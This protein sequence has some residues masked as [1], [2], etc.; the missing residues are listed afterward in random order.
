MAGGDVLGAKLVGAVDQS[1]EFQIL[2]A[3]DARV[4]RA[5]GFVFVGEI[6][7]DLG[8][9]FRGFIDE[10]VRHAE[11]V[12]D[13]AGVADGLRAAAF[14]L[15]ARDADLRPEFEGD[16]DDVKAL[17]DQKG[18]GGGGIDSSAHAKGHT[19]SLFRLHIRI[20]YGREGDKIPSFKFF[21]E[22]GARIGKKG[23]IAE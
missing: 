22:K 1:A 6:L 3:H 4:G 11:L 19:R 15:G 8:L 5:A 9:K 17:P 10:I 7:D 16:A 21:H 12:A 13:G 14:V 2:V 18:G 23:R 20:V